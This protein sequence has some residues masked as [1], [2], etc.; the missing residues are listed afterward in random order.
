MNPPKPKKKKSARLTKKKK[1]TK[2]SYDDLSNP[3]GNGIL[4]DPR[5]RT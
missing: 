5:D 1:N 4:C 3:F 2:N